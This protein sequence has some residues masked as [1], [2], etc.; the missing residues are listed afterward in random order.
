M[1][2]G[3]KVKAFLQ[4]TQTSF[5]CTNVKI[6]CDSDA[7]I[8]K[9]C[10]PKFLKKYVQTQNARDR[11][12]SVCK[13]SLFF[14]RIRVSAFCFMQAY[15]LIYMALVWRQVDKIS[16]ICLLSRVGKSAIQ[17]QWAVTAFEWYE[18]LWTDRETVYNMTRSQVI[19]ILT[20]SLALIFFTWR[21]V[22]LN[23]ISESHNSI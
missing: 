14:N 21:Q 23:L 17:T 5:L 15:Y 22:K 16:T 4:Y 13:I 7:A 10:L 6:Y 12:V 9:I 8:G 20:S 19:W 18:M 3:F 2:N 11:S 1:A